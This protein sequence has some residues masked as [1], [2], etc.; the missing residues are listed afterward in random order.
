MY[1]FLF[2]SAITLV[3]IAEREFTWTDQELW[4]SRIFKIEILLDFGTGQCDPL[5]EEPDKFYM[6]FVYVFQTDIL[7]LYKVSVSPRGLS[8][9]VDLGVCVRCIRGTLGNLQ[10]LEMEKHTELQGLQGI[11]YAL[12]VVSEAEDDEV[13]RLKALCN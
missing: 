10:I 3:R 2:F 12:G 8:C 13:C 9:S 11:V 4:N 7:S 5:Q 6:V 1:I